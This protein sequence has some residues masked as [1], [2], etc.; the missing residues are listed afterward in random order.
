MEIADP[1]AT[2]TVFD[3]QVGS[4]SGGPY[5]IPGVQGFRWRVAEV[6]YPI[7]IAEVRGG[8]G[9]LFQLEIDCTGYDYEP[10]AVRYLR[11]NG[12]PIPWSLMS[13]LGRFYLHTDSMR[14][15]M[16]QDIVSLS[17]TKGFVCVGGHLGYHEAHP[18]ENWFEVRLTLGRLF[19]IVETSIR[20]VDFGKAR[21]TL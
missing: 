8:P 3:R 11:D 6:R 15:G 21:R 5:L 2:R 19:S 1:V 7:F 9:T 17:E 20:A 18:M 16:F 14:K 10:P 4:V 13:G 12:D